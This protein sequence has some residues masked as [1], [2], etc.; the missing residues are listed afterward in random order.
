MRKLIIIVSL[1]LSLFACSNQELKGSPNKQ[2]EEVKKEEDKKA[3]KNVFEKDAVT[4]LPEKKLQKYDEGKDV[5]ALQKK[6]IEFGYPIEASGIY[7]ELTLW[8]ITDL[9]LEFNPKYATGLFDEATYKLL[10]DLLKNDTSYQAGTHLEA[11][12]E[13]D[14]L[15]DIIENPYDVLAL[16]NKSHALPSNYEP[17]DLTVPDVRFPFTEDDPKKQLRHVAAEALED[18]FKAADKAG[19]TLYAQSGFRSFDRQ[20]TIFNNNVAKHGEKHANTYSARPGQS[21]HQTGLV[22]DVTSQSV[23]FLLEEALGETPE[24]IWL[25]KEA[26]HYG[27]II[28]YPKGKESITKYQYEPWHLRYVG[29]DLAKYLVENDLTLDEY[30]AKKASP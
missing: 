16:V 26:H 15:T 21:E 12:K 4:D 29:V 5:Q 22:M 13:A 24:G 9:Q 6:L 14:R 23:G 18:L 30:Y 10:L 3:T 2:T 19:H 17:G 28:R 27:F 11:P 7:D 1:V 8:A 25:E 20:T